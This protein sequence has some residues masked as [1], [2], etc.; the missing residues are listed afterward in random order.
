MPRELSAYLY[1]SVRNRCMDRLRRKAERPLDDAAI[2]LIVAP[3]GDEER[4]ELGRLL[5]RALCALPAEQAE[6][7]VLRTW[8]D[9]EFATIAGMQG[10]SVNTALSRYQYGLTKLRKELGR[11]GR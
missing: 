9:L 3:G 6:V 4:I 5:N 8:H 1:V 11:H 10:T 7:V 2:E